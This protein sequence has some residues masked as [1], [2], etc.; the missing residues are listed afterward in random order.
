VPEQRLEIATA[1]GVADS[2]LALPEGELRGAVVF[3]IDAY[4]LREQTEAMA[5]RI[6]AEGYAVLVPNTLYR[7]GRAPVLPMPDFK[8]AASREAFMAQVKPLMAELTPAAM[9]G[10]GAAY[11]DA[12]AEHALGPVALSGYCM[13]G[14]LGWRIATAHPDRVAALACFHTGGLVSDADDSPHRSAAELP[15]R[16]LYFG[17]ADQDKSMTAEQ[18]DELE[19]TLDAAGASYTSEVYPGAQH[20]YTMADTGAYDEGAAER[21][22]DELFALLARTFPS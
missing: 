6:A 20:G 12:L 18:I 13:G 22:F 9:A 17:F 5:R 16:E 15:P 14:R 7:A 3:L 21:H 4:G 19:R 11:L 10:D 8:D 2:Y 1:D